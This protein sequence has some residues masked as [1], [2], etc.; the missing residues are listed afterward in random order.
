VTKPAEDVEAVIQA[1]GQGTRLGLGPKAFL[2]LAGSTLLERAVAT[3]LTIAPRVIVAVP[4]TELAR[5]QRLVDSTATTVI[6]GGMRRPDTLRAL[7]RASTAPWLVLH[8]VVHP[9]VTAELSHGVL[10][11][12]RRV[13]AAAAALPIREFVYRTNGELRAAPGEVVSMRK[14]VAFRRADMLRGF[15]TMDAAN[16]SNDLRDRSALEILALAGQATA[17]VPARSINFKLT[18]ADDFEIALHLASRF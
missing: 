6:A 14:P 13:G 3:M 10:A 7:V 1:A 16:E 12:A 2:A 4:A 11:E 8:D 9:F 17:F 5:A 18:T 15:A